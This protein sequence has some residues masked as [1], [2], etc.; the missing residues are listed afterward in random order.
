MLQ[1]Q[2]PVNRSARDFFHQPKNGDSALFSSSFPPTPLTIPNSNSQGKQDNPDQCIFLGP[3][4]EQLLP[5]QD[6]YIAE[7][8]LLSVRFL[9]LS[10]LGLSSSTSLLTFNPPYLIIYT[11]FLVLNYTYNQSLELI[12]L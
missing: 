7:T 4:S 12:N 8:C 1:A 10:F 6:D 5:T 9:V 11:S 2:N 3:F